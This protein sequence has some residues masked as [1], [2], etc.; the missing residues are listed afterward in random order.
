M[1]RNSN[2]NRNATKSSPLS[3]L[4]QNPFVQKSKERLNVYKS[5]LDKWLRSEENFIAPYL[6]IVEQKT[7]IPRSAIFLVVVGIITLYLLFG[8]H[9][10]FLSHL[11]TFVYPALGSLRALE[12]Q[13]KDDDKKWLT[14]WVVFGF[15]GLFEHFG[16]SVLSVLP[17]YYVLKTGF[18]LW[19]CLPGV[20]NGSLIIYDRLLRPVAK[21]ALHIDMPATGS[22]AAQFQGRINSQVDRINS[23]VDNAA[24]YVKETTTQIRDTVNSKLE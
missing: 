20:Q 6:T 21:R 8:A 15:L 19:L 2:T 14:Y 24:S 16:E 18:Q 5:Q 10:G 13:R 4:E 23:Q 17:F 12:T 9:A 1:S 3:T 22:A 7:N 11:I